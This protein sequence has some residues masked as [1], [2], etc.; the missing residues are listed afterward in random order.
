MRH[1]HII[2]M[3]EDELVHYPD[4]TYEIEQGRTHLRV[5]LCHR[6]RRRFVLM[7]KSASDHRAL[8]N[9]RRDVRHMLAAMGLKPRL[10]A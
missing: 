9:Q 8:K 1:K 2:Q 10:T 4:T 3:L 7:S 5:W 6:G